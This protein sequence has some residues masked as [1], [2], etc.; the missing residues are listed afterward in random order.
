MR[1]LYVVQRYGEE[2]AGGA[3]QH[4]RAFAER[5]GR[6]G[7]PR[8]RAHHVR[9]VVRR[10]GEHVP[11]RLVEA[12]T[13]SRCSGPA[14][15]RA[16]QPAL[17]RTVQRP[18]EQRA[19]RAPARRCSASGCRCRA[20]T[21]PTSCRGSAGNARTYDAVVFI[22]YLYWPTWAGLREC[23][24][25]VPTLL[26]PTA[27]DEPPLRLSIFQEVMRA[28]DAFAFLTP[29]E[30]DLVGERFPGSPA[31]EVVGIGVETDSTGRPRRVPAHV[32]ARRGPVPPLRRAGR[33]RQGRVGAHRLFHRVQAA[34][35]ERPAARAARRVARRR[36]GS[37]RHRHD[38]LR[39]RADPERRARRHA[40]A[41]APVVLRELR[42]G[43][44]RG[45]RAAPARAGAAAL[46]GARAATPSAAA[47]PFPTAASPS[48]RPRSTCST[49]R[50]S[51]P[52]RWARPGAGTSSR[53]TT[54][55]S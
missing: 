14:G 55:T 16:P 3:E 1:V 13:A 36:P 6:A 51:W 4:A 5:H 12:R 45:V 25:A 42:D 23:A 38:R 46:R 22:T 15:R 41:R 9:E 11:A 10:L 50:P 29:E 54:G 32:R 17:V 34:E 49:R 30:A 7:P 24:G 53:S 47:A 28:P 31:G 37:S 35:S 43:A 19:E 21:R 39:R 20:R 40:C 18:A 8:D 26:H 27:H 33:S 44:H 2:I 48:S 52:T